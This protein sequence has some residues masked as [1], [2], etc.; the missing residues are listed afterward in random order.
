[1]KRTA[2]ISGGTRGIGAQICRRLKNGGMTVVATYAGNDERARAFHAETSIAIYKWDVS[3]FDACAKGVARVVED[4]GPIDVLVNNAG[5]TRDTTL[6]KMDQTAW[7]EV[8]DTNLGGC[9]NLCRA[10]FPSMCER[11]L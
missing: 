7:Q 2:L 11:G 4:I 9:F 5:I 6:V 3:D 8:V 10:V 1:M